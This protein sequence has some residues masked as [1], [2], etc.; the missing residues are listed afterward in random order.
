MNSSYRLA[1]TDCLINCLQD[2]VVNVRE[3]I[4]TEQGSKHLWTAV[5]EAEMLLSEIDNHG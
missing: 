3:D 5:E 2:L 4:P 1:L